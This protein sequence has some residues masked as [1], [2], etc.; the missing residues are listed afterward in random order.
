MAILPRK[1]KNTVMTVKESYRKC[2]MILIPLKKGDLKDE[3]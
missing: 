1:N 3:V 2:I